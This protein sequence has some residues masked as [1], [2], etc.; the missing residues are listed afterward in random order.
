MTVREII[1]NAEHKMAEAGIEESNMLQ[2]RTGL[3]C[4]LI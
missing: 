3:P 2:G 4:F 1:E